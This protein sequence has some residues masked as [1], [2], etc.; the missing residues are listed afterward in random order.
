VKEPSADPVEPTV[1]YCYIQ[2]TSMASPHVAGVAALIISQFGS[3]SGQKTMNPGSVQ[4]YLEQT[5]DPQ[6]CPT[7]L[8]PGYASFFGFNSGLP[9]VCQGG[10]GHSSWYGS[11]QVNAFNAVTHT[12]GN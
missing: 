4:A 7:T 10:P 11:G 5:A 1:V 2:G 8:P 12:S 9:Q 3:A 6:P